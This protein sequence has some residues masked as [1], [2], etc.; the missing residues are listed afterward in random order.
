MK[1]DITAGIERDHCGIDIEMIAKHEIEII[2]I[3][4]VRVGAIGP[5]LSA[6]ESD[7]SDHAVGI[8]IIA[9]CIGGA[10]IAI[11]RIKAPVEAGPRAHQIGAFIGDRRPAVADCA[12]ARQSCGNAG[13]PSHD[14]LPER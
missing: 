7:P 6:A 4:Q 8:D 5:V 13:S 11:L 12:Q 3:D 1:I 10:S 2:V 14:P 9:E